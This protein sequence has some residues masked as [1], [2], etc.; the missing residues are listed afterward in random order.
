AGL[1]VLFT[2]TLSRPRPEFRKMAEEAGAEIAGGVSG[3]LDY[4]IVGANPGS[5]LAQA[6]ALDIPVLDEAGFLAL[7]EGA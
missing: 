6:R 3:K 1:R 4:L 7:L 2:G 5:K